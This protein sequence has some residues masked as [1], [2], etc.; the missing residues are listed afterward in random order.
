MDLARRRNVRVLA[1]QVK[2]IDLQGLIGNRKADGPFVFDLYLLN[3]G[4]KIVQVG[5]KLQFARPAQW[6]HHVDFAVRPRMS[7]QSSAHVSPEDRVQFQL[8]KA[9]VHIRRP[10]VT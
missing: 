6:T 3:I 9:E 1:N 5:R 7:V 8:P 2:L 10:V 4:V